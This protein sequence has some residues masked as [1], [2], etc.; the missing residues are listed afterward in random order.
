MIDVDLVA[1]LNARVTALEAELI[2]NALRY[3]I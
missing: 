3:G 1:Q 2:K